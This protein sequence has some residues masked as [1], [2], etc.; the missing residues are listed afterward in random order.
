MNFLRPNIE[1][2]PQRKRQ[3]RKKSSAT[4]TLLPLRRPDSR[5]GGIPPCTALQ[6]IYGDLLSYASDFLVHQT[7]CTS[8]GARGLAQHV[9]RKYP[10][11]NTYR[12]N[13]PCRQVGTVSFHTCDTTTAPTIVNLY[14]QYGTGTN[15]KN[16]KV[17]IKDDQKT[18][19]SYFRLGLIDLENKLQNNNNNNNNNKAT[20]AFPFGIGCNLAGGDWSTYRTMISRFA[21]RNQSIVDVVIVQLNDTN[22]KAFNDKARTPGKF[23]KKVTTTSST[24][25]TELR[26]KAQATANRQKVTSMTIPSTNIAQLRAKAQARANRLSAS[27]SSSAMSGEQKS[28]SPSSKNTTLVRINGSHGEGGG[29]IMRISLALSAITKYNLNVTNIRAGRSVPGLR[30]QHVSCIE[31]VGKMMG[32]GTTHQ[33]CQVGTK[34]FLLSYGAAAPTPAN[35]VTVYHIDTKSAGSITLLI[36]ACLPVQIARCLQSNQS[37]AV[38]LIGGTEVSF[39]PPMDHVSHVLLPLLRQHYLNNISI[40]LKVNH[41]GFYP[42]G[43]GSVTLSV[44]PKTTTLPCTINS[45][46]LVQRGTNIVRLFGVIRCHGIT[47]T[48]FQ[49]TFQQYL[50][51]HVTTLAEHEKTNVTVECHTSGVGGSGVGGSGVGGNTNSQQQ[52]KNKNKNTNKNSNSNNSNKRRPNRVHRAI[53][54]QLV[55]VTNTGCYLSSNCLRQLKK[56]KSDEPPSFITKKLMG[57]LSEACTEMNGVLASGTCVD[58]HTSDQLLVYMALERYFNAPPKKKQSSSTESTGSIILTTPCRMS[59][60]SN[61]AMDIISQNFQHTIQFKVQNQTAAK[62][63]ATAIP[64]EVPVAPL[65]TIAVASGVEK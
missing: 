16:K 54:C 30:N 17:K 35:G 23:E 28:H 56:V 4:T 13:D 19:E 65:R 33:A 39:S 42:Q 9:F 43:G 20:V 52:N 58:E 37:T 55:A 51:D 29:Q 44:S 12:T 26:A 36:Q 27:A 46:Q 34:E 38:T 64:K 50:I 8:T 41:R 10:F 40:D 15:K 45:L 59:Q 63:S 32:Q 6:E 60:H 25:V 22:M 48:N 11:A 57:V 14:G 24:N 18:R 31:L 61:T 62:A 47:L 53:V 7:N 49:D 1:P 21:T 5:D 3:R 2:L